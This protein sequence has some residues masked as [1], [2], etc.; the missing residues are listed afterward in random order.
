MRFNAARV[1]WAPSIIALGEP[2]TKNTRQHVRK[3]AAAGC[4]RGI[5]GIF[6]GGGAFAGEGHAGIPQLREAATAGGER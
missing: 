1:P 2:P 4:T 5:R 3:H 6:L